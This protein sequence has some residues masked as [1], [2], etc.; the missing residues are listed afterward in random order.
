[1]KQY[2]G[3]ALALTFVYTLSD[4]G[5]LPVPDARVQPAR[6][7]HC[8]GP[9]ALEDPRL[10]TVSFDPEHDAPEVL[11]RYAEPFV[12]RAAPTA[13]RLGAHHRHEA[14]GEG[15]GG[16]LRPSFWGEG[17]DIAHSL[18]TGIVGPGGTLLKVYEDNDWTTDDA[19]A[20]LREA[21]EDES[22]GVS[23]HRNDGPQGSRHLRG[24]SR[25]GAAEVEAGGGTYL[26][27][28]G[29]PEVLEGDWNPSRVVILRFKD[30]QS[31]KTWWAWTRTSGEG[32][33]HRRRPQPHGAHGAPKAC[34][35]SRSSG[36]AA[37]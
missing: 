24:I 19:L 22:D 32:A 27:R 34:R 33:A 11:R 30:R 23:H 25:Q 29:D 16:V 2:R 4:P 8:E 37:R 12:G 21:V 1:M 10:F 35:S 20:S 6:G 7:S 28:G 5:V 18:R 17:K 31:A 3:R 14:A 9:A 36:C 26:V 15:R 13:S